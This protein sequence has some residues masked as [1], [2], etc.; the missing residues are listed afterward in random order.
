MPLTILRA[1]HSCKTKRHFCVSL[2]YKTHYSVSRYI[3]EA[4]YSIMLHGRIGMYRTI[5]AET[6]PFCQFCV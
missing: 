3:G 6:A 4:E 2:T 5:M 1:V